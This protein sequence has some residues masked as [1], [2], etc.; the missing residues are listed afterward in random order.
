MIEKI[1]EVP[2]GFRQ[3]GCLK[4]RRLGIIDVS[5]G[6]EPMSDGPCLVSRRKSST[7]EPA[8]DAVG[9]ADP[10]FD[11][12]RLPPRDAVVDRLPRAIPVIGMESFKEGIDCYFRAGREVE[13][14]TVG[15]S[16]EGKRSTPRLE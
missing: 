13:M 8:I 14:R 5:A 15:R 12:V 4:L 10:I 1:G 6:A 2:T 9:S 7:Q 16:T 3:K 11:L